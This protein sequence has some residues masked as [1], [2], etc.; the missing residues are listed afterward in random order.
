MFFNQ[1]FIVNQS[2]YIFRDNMSRR[3]EKI[4]GFEVS[5]LRR[6]L[7]VYSLIAH[8]QKRIAAARHF[9]FLAH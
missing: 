2:E 9:I 3:P 8:R 4:C 1:S 6:A 5:T 7:H